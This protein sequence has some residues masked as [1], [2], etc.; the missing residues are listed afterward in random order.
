VIDVLIESGGR[1]EL[2]P[3]LEAAV[4]AVLEHER[5]EG[6]EVSLTLLGDE[7]IQELNREHLAHDYPTDVL[8]FALWQEGEPVVGDVYVGYDQA[9]R[10]AEREGVTPLD[11]LC[12]LAI[13]GT[14]HVLGY[15]HPEA[16]E[17]RGESEMYRLQE[18]ILAGLGAP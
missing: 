4:R 8:S 7:A 12:R 2:V 10:Q 6:G 1:P 5:I 14:L 15:D 9:L 3:S 13:H 16:E 17:E 11:E 18:K